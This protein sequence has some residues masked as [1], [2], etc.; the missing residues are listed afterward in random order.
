MSLYS[1]VTVAAKP[2]GRDRFLVSEPGFSRF[3]RLAIHISLPVSS[4]EIRF[5][6]EALSCL[7]ILR[8]YTYIP[9]GLCCRMSAVD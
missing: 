8:F 5:R 9:T 1:P 6:L 3:C 4:R 2:A 7:F